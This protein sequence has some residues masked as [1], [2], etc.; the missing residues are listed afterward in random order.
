MQNP[1]GLNLPRATASM[2]P[3]PYYR[4]RII[5]LYKSPG[6]SNAIDINHLRLSPTPWK[7]RGWTYLQKT[8]RQPRHIRD[9]FKS[10]GPTLPP[11]VD[12]ETTH[13]AHFRHSKGRSNEFDQDSLSRSYNAS[14]LM[15]DLAGSVR[16]KRRRLY[17]PNA[18]H[19]TLGGLLDSVKSSPSSCMWTAVPLHKKKL[20]RLE[21]NSSVDSSLQRMHRSQHCP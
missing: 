13:R 5:E 17:K 11:A 2:D 10:S 7:P 14:P 3:P 9:M 18:K 16:P 12:Y 6:A 8:T 20:E 19:V 21:L 4:H 15:I 1:S